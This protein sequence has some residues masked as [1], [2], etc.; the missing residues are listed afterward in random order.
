MI[1]FDETGQLVCPKCG[2]NRFN[3]IQKPAKLAVFECNE[4]L[5]ICGGV[6]QRHIIEG[7]E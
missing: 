7:T 6:E 1:K 5:W 2:D 4:C 3:I